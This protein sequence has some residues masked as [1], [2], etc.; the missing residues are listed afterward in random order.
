MRS[1][2]TASGAR[3][4]RSAIVRAPMNT[5]AKYKSISDIPTLALRGITVF[6]GALFHFDVGR[7]K[8]IQALEQAMIIAGVGWAKPV[9]I[10]PRRMTRLKN[11]KVA[12]SLTALAGPV[13]NLL[14]AFVLFF[15][16]LELTVHGSGSFVTG[17]AQFLYITAYLSVG[18]AAF[19]LLPIP[20]LD[21]SKILLPLLPDRL[22]RTVAKYERYLSLVFLAVIMHSEGL[23]L[24]TDDGELSYRLMHPSHE[25]YK[26][27]LVHL[28]PDGPET[29]PPE[30]TLSRPMELDGQRLLPARVRVVRRLPAGGYIITMW[31]KIRR[32]YRNF[33]H[34]MPASRSL[35]SPKPHFCTKSM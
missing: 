35:W 14:L 25:V 15:V 19:N 4:Q 10:D 23:L 17:L 1:D 34:F 27:Y 24:M 12:V 20:P 33:A 13:S 18:L 22:I 28:T 11:R 31:P 21:G 2:S 30:Q 16:Y 26:E 29:A 6:P 7:Q 9:P 5:T 32:R 8:S 3:S